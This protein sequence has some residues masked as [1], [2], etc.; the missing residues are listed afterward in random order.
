MIELQKSDTLSSGYAGV[1]E[2]LSRANDKRRFSVMG[3]TQ[4]GDQLVMGRFATAEEAA[5][6]RH[7]ALKALA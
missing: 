6:R 1:R 7:N 3:T 4:N 5:L 2:N